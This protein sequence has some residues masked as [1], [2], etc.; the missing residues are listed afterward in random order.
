[1]GK[2]NVYFRLIRINPFLLVSPVLALKY[3]MAVLPT[4]CY[5]GDTDSYGASVR[6]HPTLLETI[7]YLTDNQNWV[8]AN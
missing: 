2:C 6:I 8:Y 3:P 5:S 4:R 1:M 7:L